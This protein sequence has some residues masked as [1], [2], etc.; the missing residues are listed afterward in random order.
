MSLIFRIVNEKDAD[1]IYLNGEINEDAELPLKEV[2]ENVGVSCVL[3]LGDISNFNAKSVH[4]WIGFIRKLESKCN[5]VL[6]D[7]CPKE[8]IF[9]LNYIPSLKGKAQIRSLYANY[10]C[11]NCDREKLELYTLG[12]NLPK[13]P[14]SKTLPKVVCSHCKAVMEMEEVEEEYFECIQKQL[15]E[16]T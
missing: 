6:I 8:F 15:R 14:S 13:N 12:K 16:T 11:S 7:E 3:N 1:I 5:V 4:F 2:I 10:I 9:H